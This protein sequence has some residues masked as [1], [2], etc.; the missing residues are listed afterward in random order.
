MN[1][2]QSN[3]LQSTVMSRVIIILTILAATLIST[4]THALRGG[5]VIKGFP[6]VVEGGGCT[7]SMIAPN[8]ILTAA[9]CLDVVGAGPSSSGSARFI[10][11]YHDPKRGVL[12]SPDFDGTATWHVSPSYIRPLTIGPSPDYAGDANADHGVIVISSSVSGVD[13]LPNTDYHD[14]LRIYSDKKEFLKTNLHLYGAGMHSYSGNSDNKLR[15]HW[16]EIENVEYNHIVMDTRDKV[17]ICGGDSGGPFIYKGKASGH[18]VPMIAGVLS[19]ME[20][21]DFESDKCSN[22]DPPRDD[23]FVSRIS[24]KVIRFIEQRTGISCRVHSNANKEYV[25]CFDLPFIEDIGYEGLERD[26]AVAIAVS[27]II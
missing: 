22:N 16:F 18:D 9:H 24:W 1:H 15:T 25:R 8:V 4:S 14:Y 23:A 3:M 11:F 6:G 2:F 10:I 12:K 26:L 19:G 27:S 7:G 17:S 21:G 20:T 13:R 5:K